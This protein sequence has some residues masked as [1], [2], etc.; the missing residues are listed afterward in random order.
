MKT[1]K[2]IILSG[3]VLSIVL[4]LAVLSYMQQPTKYTGID[5]TYSDSQTIKTIL[6][7]KNIF[8][9]SPTKISDYTV[10]QYC[11]YFDDQNKQQIMNECVTTSLTDPDGNPLGN[12]NIGGRY[13]KPLMAV[14][15][16]E[17][18]PLLDSQKNNLVTVFDAMISTWVC[19]CWQEKQPGGFESLSQWIQAAENHHVNSGRDS[20]KSKISGFEGKEIILEISKADDSYLWTLIIIK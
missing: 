20:T 5:F 19:D 2:V 6:H 8:M 4:I 13:E 1:K 16:V 9:S 7:S 10:K 18:S 12:I 17:S 14:A 3:S 15:I 11:M